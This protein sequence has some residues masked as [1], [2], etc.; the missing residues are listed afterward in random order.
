[1]VGTWCFHQA[2][3]TKPLTTSCLPLPAP[4]PL[5]HPENACKELKELR[6]G[7]QESNWDMLVYMSIEVRM[8][9]QNQNVT[10]YYDHRLDGMVQT[11]FC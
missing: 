7:T 11:G 9:A 5:P 10:C 4:T 2:S 6:M 1:M 8:L 3:L